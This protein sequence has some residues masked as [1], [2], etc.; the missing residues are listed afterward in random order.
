MRLEVVRVG[1]YR[2][3]NRNRGARDNGRTSLQGIVFGWT[4]AQTRMY[5][6]DD[7]GR[8]IP[9]TAYRKERRML[10]AEPLGTWT[11]RNMCKLKTGDG[12][13]CVNRRKLFHAV[14]LSESFRSRYAHRAVFKLEA[15]T[16]TPPCPSLCDPVLSCI[17]R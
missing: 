10:S 13:A 11:H 5:C 16:L 14:T 1:G 3:H 4:G 6:S 7:S 2:R 12:E 17:T 15:S 9:G 8:S